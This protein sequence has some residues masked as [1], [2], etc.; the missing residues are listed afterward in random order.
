MLLVE[1][2]KLVTKEAMNGE[3]FAFIEKREMRMRMEREK[4][5]V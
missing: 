5:F 2:M 1:G 4:R 3:G